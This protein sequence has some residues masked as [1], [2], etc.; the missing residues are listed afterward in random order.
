ME[1]AVKAFYEWW[2]NKYDSNT[3]VLNP[4]RFAKEVFL[5]G[6][7]Y[8]DHAYKDIKEY[9]EIVGYEINDTFRDGWNMARATNKMLGI[10]E[11]EAGVDK[12]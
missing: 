5:A 12:D 7:E 6:V 1:K 8:T 2:M 3:I 4:R 9:E 10:K 11:D